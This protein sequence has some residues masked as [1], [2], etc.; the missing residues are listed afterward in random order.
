MDLP[1]NPAHHSSEV[2]NNVDTPSTASHAIRNP[3]IQKD[4]KPLAM[5]SYTLTRW[6]LTA[7]RVA[8]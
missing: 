6:P 2:C 8:L 1:I 3:E 4:V 5:S 7:G